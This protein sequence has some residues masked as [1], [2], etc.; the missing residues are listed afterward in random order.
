MSVSLGDELQ[1]VF[2]N[3]ALAHDQSARALNDLARV[4]G[5][6]ERAK[7]AKDCGKRRIVH[8]CKKRDGVAQKR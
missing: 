4:V 1:R 2:D 7:V 8:R 6:L 3:M 5:L